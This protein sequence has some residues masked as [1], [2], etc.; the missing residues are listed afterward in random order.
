MAL[1]ATVCPVLGILSHGSAGLPQKVRP[2]LLFLI[3]PFWTNS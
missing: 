3:V 1:I 2:L